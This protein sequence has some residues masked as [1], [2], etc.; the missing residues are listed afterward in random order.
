MISSGPDRCWSRCIKNSTTSCFADGLVEDLQ[1]EAPPGHPCSLKWYC[2]TRV[3]PRDAP[4]RQ[5]CGRWLNPLS[6]LQTIVRP[7]FW[8][9]FGLWPALP[10]PP[11]NGGFVAFQ[12]P[13]GGPLHTPVQMRKD[14]PDMPGMMTSNS[15]AIRSDT[16]HKSKRV[17]SYP[18]RS[19]PFSSN[20]T[21]RFRSAMLNNGLRPGRPVLR[22]RTHLWPVLRSP[23]TDRLIANL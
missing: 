5:R 10:F 17:V 1:I 9:F 22:K 23:A 4:A 19:G 18:S 13:A 8:A 15:C 21:K 14:L 7:S 16:G 20:S 2:S 3:R 6:S 11:L 12:R